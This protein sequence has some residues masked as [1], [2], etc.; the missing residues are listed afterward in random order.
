MSYDPSL[1]IDLRAWRDSHLVFD[2]AAHRFGDGADFEN[3]R[4]AIHAAWLVQNYYFALDLA[5]RYG[6]ED[7]LC[8]R[9]TQRSVRAANALYANV[10]F[11]QP[12]ST[13]I[14]AAVWRTLCEHC[15]LDLMSVK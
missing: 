1:S 11:G 4:H 6:L 15:C 3:V 10:T 14:P 5:C 8:L 12:R 13:Q 7:V 2:G 9:C